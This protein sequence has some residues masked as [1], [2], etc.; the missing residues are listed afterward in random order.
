MTLVKW[1]PN[2]E[3]LNYFNDVDTIINQAFSHSMETEH[4]SRSFRPFM[5]VNESDLE[6]TVFMDLP[7]VDKKD[8]EVNMSE[9]ILTII[10]ERNNNEQGQD[11]PCI[12]KENYHGTFLRSFELSNAVQEDKIKARFKNGVL[13]IN[14][15]KSE[16]VK[17]AVK[18]ITV[19]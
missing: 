5:N 3:M 15:P 12:L 14:I 6:Y 10:G 7:G 9:G 4:E 19:N 13:T 2:R 16:E 18:K 17:P 11:N 8:V 1:T